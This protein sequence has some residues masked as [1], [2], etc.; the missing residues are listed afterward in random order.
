MLLLLFVVCYCLVSACDDCTR[1]FLTGFRKRKAA[2]REYAQKKQM[3]AVHSSS[4]LPACCFF[5]DGSSVKHTSLARNRIL[6]ADR[7]VPT[8]RHAANCPLV[9]VLT[10]TGNRFFTFFCCV[11]S[12]PKARREKIEERKLR[13][14]IA[15]ACQTEKGDAPS[16]S[17]SSVSEVLMLSSDLFVFGCCCCIVLLAWVSCYVVVVVV[18]SRCCLLCFSLLA[19][20]LHCLPDTS[21]ERQDPKSAAPPAKKLKFTDGDRS[22]TVTVQ[23]GDDGGE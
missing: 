1:D 7:I 20:C 21:K 16:S 2:R 4:L 17:S 5:L 12:L 9:G 13:K 11:M 3:E 10:L 23:R 19:R 15:A 14:R 6:S 8:A 22:V 18:M